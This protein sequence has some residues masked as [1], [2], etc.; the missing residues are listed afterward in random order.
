METQLSDKAEINRWIT[1]HQ[2][3]SQTPCDLLP[4]TKQHRSEQKLI[5]VASQEIIFRRLVDKM[6]MMQVTSGVVHNDLALSHVISPCFHG[7]CLCFV[8]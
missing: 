4:P 7:K 5:T 6:S 2:G 1:H 3:V 8:F